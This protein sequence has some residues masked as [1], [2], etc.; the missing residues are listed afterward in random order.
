MAF[1]KRPVAFKRNNFIV[2]TEFKHPAW[3]V[4]SKGHCVF[5]VFPGVAEGGVMTPQ[6]VPVDGEPAEG[7]G[8]SFAELEVVSF[9]GKDKLT[10]ITQ[11][12]DVDLTEFVS[13]CRMFYNV[14]EDFIEKETNKATSKEGFSDAL[15]VWKPWFAFKGIASLPSVNM[16]LQGIL[17]EHGGVP[18]TNKKGA[19]CP[20]YPVVLYMS[21]SATDYMESKLTTKLVANEDISADNSEMGDIT[22]LDKGSCIKISSYENAEKRTRYKVERL[23]DTQ[24]NPLIS[25]LDPNMVLSHFKPWEELLDI[26][27]A[28][29][30]INK[31]VEQFG[32]EAVD[33]AFREDALYGPMLPKEVAGTY[34][35][36]F[37]SDTPQQTISMSKQA[38]I[39]VPVFTQQPVVQQP[40]QT[41]ATQGPAL[42]QQPAAEPNG[43]MEAELVEDDDNIPYDFQGQRDADEEKPAAPA[44]TGVNSAVAM[45]MQTAKNNQPK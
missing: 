8:D 36:T 2:R 1:L 11:P 16:L 23:T 40:T 31:L 45:A 19:V 13:P 4:G 42:T 26:Q 20:K 32:P 21:K 10:F 9:L 34:A 5:R 35:R 6:I 15:T 30:Q 28:A 14:L 37:E 33:Y 44:N 7:L 25:K 27:S 43:F 39:K 29:W 18:C 24:G 41:A 22:S 17:V 3:N 12:S 38:D